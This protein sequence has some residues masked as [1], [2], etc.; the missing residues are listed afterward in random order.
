[1]EYVAIVTAL[2]LLQFTWFGVQVGAMR[3]KHKIKAPAMFGQSEFDRMYRVHYNTLEQ[4]VV[5]LPA[6]WLFA[7]AVNPIWAAGFGAVYLVARFI[8]RAAYLKD[9][10]GRSLGFTLSFLPSAIMLVWLLIVTV[11]KLI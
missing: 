3:A 5:V 6:M 1:M 9:P 7:E 4:L 11:M 8:Y 10:D 2:A